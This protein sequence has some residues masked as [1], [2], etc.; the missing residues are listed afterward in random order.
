[1]SKWI[2]FVLTG[3]TGKTSIWAVEGGAILGQVK[4]FGRWRGYAFFPA[5]DTV[6]E[7]TCLGDISAFIK[8]QM[9]ERRAARP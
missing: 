8:A 4:W 7:P 5:A 1:M 2:D 3:T 6:Y 9:A